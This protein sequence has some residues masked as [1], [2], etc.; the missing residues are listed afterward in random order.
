MRTNTLRSKR[1]GLEAAGA[2]SLIL[3][4]G[5][6][7]TNPGPVRDEFIALPASQ[8]GLINGTRRVLSIA[9]GNRAYTTA[10]LAREIFPGGQTGAW[11]HSVT[12]QG[13]H[14]TPGDGPEFTNLHEARFIAETAV[15]RFTQAGAADETMYEANLWGGFAYRMLGEWWCEAVV[16]STDPDVR[17]AGAYFQTTTPYFERAVEKFTAALQ[18]AATDDQRNAARAARAAANVWLKKWADAA[19]DASQVPN[20][21]VLAATMTP[22]E[23]TL[24]NDLYEANSGTFRSFTIRFTWFYDYYEQTGDPRTRWGVDPQF[25]V[26]VGSLSGFPGGRV[27]YN[28]QRKYP[29][30]DSDINLASGWEMRLIEAEAMLARG[31]WQGAMTMINQVRTRNVSDHTGEPL[32][33]WQASSLEEAWT[34]LK[35]ERYIELWLEGRRMGDERRWLADNVPGSMDTPNWEDPSHPGHTPLFTRNPRSFCFDI[36]TAERDL[37][38]NVPPLGR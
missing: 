8:Q 38:P 1:A 16:P 12:N 26:A 34:F 25:A 4:A 32:E 2:A 9:L 20:N 22:L 13:G 14:I 35:R 11:G 28:P 18:Y 5:C 6:E 19:A 3:L 21:F 33:P 23:E 15:K 7:V 27:P 37:N 10:L 30:R 17:E 29:S 36:P 31:D 24:Y